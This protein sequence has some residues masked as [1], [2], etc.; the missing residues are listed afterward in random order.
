M[1]NFMHKALCF[2]L[3]ALTISFYG[4]WFNILEKKGSNYTI[5]HTRKYYISGIFQNFFHRQ[6]S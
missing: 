2:M 6:L 4:H 5:Y 3:Y 1:H